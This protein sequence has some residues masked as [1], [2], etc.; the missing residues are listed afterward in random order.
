MNEINEKLLNLKIK[1]KPIIKEELR[2]QAEKEYERDEQL[3]REAMKKMREQLK[4]EEEEEERKK[5]INKLYMKQGMAQREAIKKKQK[6][7]EQKLEDQIREYNETIAKREE[8]INKKKAALQEA[9][10]K[11]FNKLCDEEAKR[12]AERDYWDNVRAE[13]H[14]EQDI[15]KTKKQQQAE[16]DDEYGDFEKSKDL[17]EEKKDVKKSPES[18]NVKKTDESKNAKKFQQNH[19]KQ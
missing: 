1:E 15:L 3:A 7:D 4:A 2:I 9:K 14:V 12:K 11:I 6:E 8:G 17:T 18:K 13:L 10:D 16:E 5:E 19:D